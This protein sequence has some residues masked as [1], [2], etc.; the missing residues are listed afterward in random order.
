MN[1]RWF[2]LVNPAAGGNKAG[3]IW[4]VL[5]QQLIDEPVD[6]EYRVSKNSADAIELIQ[7]AVELGYRHFIA[8]GGDGTFNLLVNGIFRHAPGKTSEYV[9]ALIPVGTGNDWIR[10]AGIPRSPKTAIQLISQSKTKMH[11]VGKITFVNDQKTEIK[12]FINMAGFGFQGLI[13]SRIEGVSSTIKKGAFAFVLG[14]LDALFRYKVTWVSI[15]ADGWRIEDHIYNMS[16]GIGRYCGGGMKMAP[17][18][19]TNDGLFDV[20]MVKAIS[21]PEVIMNIPGLFSGKFVKNRKVLRQRSQQLKIESTPMMP[22][23]CDGEVVGFG[24]AHVVILKD[25][26]MVIAP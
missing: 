26:I 2:V 21:K 4:P 1:T 12:H 24:N 8:V 17:D 18:A 7:H 22:V 11:D 15:D 3:K 23:E 25:A 19:L 6:Y 9:I 5:K 16:I 10:T 20:T 13:A 14:I